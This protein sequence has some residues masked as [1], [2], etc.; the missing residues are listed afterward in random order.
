MSK[1]T[2]TDFEALVDILESTTDA[3]VAK[4]HFFF[5]HENWVKCHAIV[6]K[7]NQVYDYVQGTTHMDLMG[8]VM[9]SLALLPSVVGAP[10]CSLRFGDA[11]AFLSFEEILEAMDWSFEAPPPAA[12]YNTRRAPA[13]AGAG[14]GSGAAD[15]APKAASS[16]FQPPPTQKG[17]DIA[18]KILRG[19]TLTDEEGKYEL[20]EDEDDSSYAPSETTEKEEDGMEDLAG[21]ME[22]CRMAATGARVAADRVFMHMM[23]LAT[24]HSAPKGVLES[25]RKTY[26]EHKQREMEAAISLAGNYLDSRGFF[27]SAPNV[28]R[29]IDKELGPYAYIAKRMLM[30]E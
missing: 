24:M 16:R 23:S 20:Y 1:I 7:R 19:E 9:A 26:E 27:G 4:P 6:T 13:A 22:K 28:D 14:A 17:R 21:R 3:C 18:K 8:W 11:R 25:V 29:I 10:I 5:A 2:Y 30:D 12:M 15:G